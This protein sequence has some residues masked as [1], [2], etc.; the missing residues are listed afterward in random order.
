M[1]Y[2]TPN[3]SRSALVTIDVQRDFV[4]K[5]APAEVAGTLEAVPE[6]SRLVSAFRRQ[7]RPVFH[8]LRLY[9]PDGSNVDLCRRS[10]VEDGTSIVAPGSAGSELVA[11]LVPAGSAA[12]DARTLL[13]GDPQLL[14]TDEW[15]LYKPRWGAFYGTRLEG[16][17]GAKGIDTLVICGCNFPN[18]PRA[19][20]Y[21]ASERDFKIVV[22][23]DAISGLYRR[24][25]EELR[26]IGASVFTTDEC[27][28]WISESTGSPVS[29]GSR[30]AS[31]A[32]GSMSNGL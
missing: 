17:L 12:L 6:M 30:R 15:A 26:A 32:S 9:V 27:L 21:E 7:G 29:S 1:S 19:T 24:G 16:I 11:D 14:S 3:P 18:C 22:A 31:V 10:L 13:A 8:I 2:L 23:A 28:A 5:G 4:L 25:E 20:I